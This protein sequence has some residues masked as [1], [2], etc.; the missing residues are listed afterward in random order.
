MSDQNNERQGAITINDIARELNISPSTVSRALNDSSKISENTRAQVKAVALR[1]G[2]QINQ[3]ASALSK[4]K[5]NVLGIILPRLSSSFFSK[6]LSGIEEVANSKGYRVLICQSN[7]NLA[8]E[9]EMVK[10]LISSRVDGVV[11]A[12]AM[13]SGEAEHF[14]LFTRN[15]IPVAMFDRVSFNIPGPKVIVDNYD[16]AFR[17]TEHLIQ[18]G[19]NRIAHLTGPLSSK[20]FEERLN[21]YRDAL[22]LHKIKEDPQLILSC[23]LDEKDTRE[24]FNHWM[25][26]PQKPDAVFTGSSSSGLVVCAVAK[27]KGISIPAELGV[28]SF[29]S[30][31]CHDLMTPTLSAVDMPGSDM[32]KTATELLI[33]SIEQKREDN[34]L[35][36]NPIKLLVKNSSFRPQQK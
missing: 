10:L 29:G 26:M 21:G 28:I 16:G 19:Y 8:Q 15:R 9:T 2:Y 35:I 5:T 6:A 18:N 22:A 7:E 23:N 17:A 24:A 4:S 20:V 34:S 1:L 36:L 11:A 30:E 27:S 12:L 33:Q 13:E 25:R 32:G 31:Q 14:N 3:T